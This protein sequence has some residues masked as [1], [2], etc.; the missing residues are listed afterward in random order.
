MRD[1]LSMGGGDV[2][3]ADLSALVDAETA[4]DGLVV[5]TAVQRVA[6]LLNERDLTNDWLARRFAEAA[7]A[8]TRIAAR[9]RSGR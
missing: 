6:N 5:R 4:G 3:R 2:K 1:R 9:I 7:Q 8:M